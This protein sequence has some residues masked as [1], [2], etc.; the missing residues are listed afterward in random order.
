[1]PKRVVIHIGLPKCGSTSLQ[2]R[3]KG[4]R[5]ALWR[6]GVAYP[7]ADAETGV[8]R[9]APPREARGRPHHAR[10]AAML[11]EEG[12]ERGRA[13]LAELLA[14][15]EASDRDTLMLSSEGFA[16]WSARYG[17]DAL[18]ALRPYA[19]ELLLFVR[20]RDRWMLSMYRHAVGAGTERFRGG[21]A[22]WAAQLPPDGRVPEAGRAAAVAARMA[23][24]T[25]G[26]VRVFDL[27]EGADARALA[28]GVLGVPLERL[29]DRVGELG[30]AS[31]HGEQVRLGLPVNASLPDAETLFVAMCDRDAV[32][33]EASAELVLTLMRHGLGPAVAPLSILSDADAAALV[34]EGA[35]DRAALGLP[36]AAATV[37]AAPHRTTLSVAEWLAA[38]RRLMWFTGARTADALRLASE[39]VRELG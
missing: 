20:P 11:A 33:A 6:A 1:M 9:I 22:A 28:G 7:L 16:G 10:L 21:Y 15:F 39:R 34:A 14:D 23:A 31:R 8:P 36:P 13:V 4:A 12:G 27:G 32:D 24:M 38:A 37:P 19:P 35:A 3:L 25:G 2:V 26:R 5:G 29:A 18:A 17:A 30:A